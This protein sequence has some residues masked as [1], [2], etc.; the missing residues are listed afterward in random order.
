MEPRNEEPTD[1]EE[2][3]KPYQDEDAP[4][5]ARLIPKSRAYFTSEP[6]F[7]DNFLMIEELGRKYSHL[8][9]EELTKARRVKWLINTTGKNRLVIDIL[10]ELNKL[11]PA[12]M[13]KDV[14]RVLEEYRVNIDEGENRPK[15]ALVD[16][17]GRG[18]GAGR[19]KSS[20]AE[21]WAVEGTGEILVNGKTLVDAFGRIHD[22]ESIIWPLK[23][24]NR[25]D[26]YNIWALAS[27]GG[28]TG[29]AE[30]L[31]LAIAKA[32]VVHEPPLKTA[33]R[34]GEFPEGF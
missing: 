25:I 26:K 22:R 31:Q 3:R 12:V 6:E 19:R 29:Q 16:S 27:G 11:H 8:P 18:R 10:R 7:I 4:F 5:F 24:T 17:I 34:R 14:K 2:G 28:T 9:K 30:A 20:S 23:A 1:E 21:A 33:L 13:P 15:L 32:L